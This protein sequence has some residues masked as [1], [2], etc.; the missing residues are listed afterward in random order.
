MARGGIINSDP[1]F[2]LKYLD[3]LPSDDE[4]DDSFEGYLSDESSE[5]EVNLTLLCT[6]TCN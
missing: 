2:L 6:Y 5:S 4:S 1:E 3:A